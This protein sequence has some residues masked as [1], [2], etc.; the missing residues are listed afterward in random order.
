MSEQQTQSETDRAERTD[1]ALEEATT[2]AEGA[3]GA[4]FTVGRLWASHGLSV[5]RL[6]LER[7]AKTLE[8]TAETLGDASRRIERD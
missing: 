7:S 5:A 4:L 6:A 2:A 1:E 3:V 8:A